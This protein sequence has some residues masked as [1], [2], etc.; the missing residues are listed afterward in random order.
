M[1]RYWN[2]QGNYIGVRQRDYLA[3]C[4]GRILGKFYGKEIYDQNGN[5]IGEVGRGGRLIKNKNK[6]DF[7]RQGFSTYVKGTITAPL[8]D[9]APYPMIQGYEDFYNG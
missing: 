4:D 2:W 6:E 1:E 7:R 8:K 5:Y 9:C 3:A